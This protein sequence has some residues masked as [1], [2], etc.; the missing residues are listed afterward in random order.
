MLVS[1]S[2]AAPDP[3]AARRRRRSTCSWTRSRRPRRWPRRARGRDRRVGP[4]RVSAPRPLAL[5]SRGRI[6]RDRLA[7]RPRDVARR[8]SLHRGRDRRAGRRRRRDRHRGEHPAGVRTSPRRT[9][10]RARGRAAAVD[11]A[12]R[13]L[14][15]AIACSR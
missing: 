15:G 13:G 3:G 10:E 4:A 1:R 9:A 12:A 5:G 2:D 11:I 7:R 6:E 14:T 8:R